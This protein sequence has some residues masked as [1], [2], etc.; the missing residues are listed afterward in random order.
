M[1]VLEYCKPL[2]HHQGVVETSCR[3]LLKGMAQGAIEAGAVSNNTHIYLALVLTL[4]F[5]ML[6]ICL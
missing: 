1:K 6:G 5:E 4:F 2:Q 3:R